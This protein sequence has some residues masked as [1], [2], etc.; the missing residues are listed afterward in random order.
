MGEARVAQ[1]S[2]RTRGSIAYVPQFAWIQAGTV[3]TIQEIPC[4]EHILFLLP[5]YLPRIF[6]A[7]K[8]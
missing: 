2:V 8:S 7:E 6:S 1:G 5:N 3:R 4:P